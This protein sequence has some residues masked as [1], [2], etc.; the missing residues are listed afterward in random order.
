MNNEDRALLFQGIRRRIREIRD[1]LEALGIGSLVDIDGVTLDDALD[2]VDEAVSTER[3]RERLYG[4]PRER[5]WI[6]D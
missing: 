5:M 4:R 6:P 1:S 3:E 2:Q